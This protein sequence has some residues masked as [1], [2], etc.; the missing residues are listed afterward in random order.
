MEVNVKIHLPAPGM[1]DD[2]DPGF[3][4]KYMEG[5]DELWDQGLISPPDRELTTKAQWIG[6]KRELAQK[7][8]WV[9]HSEAPYGGP[10]QVIKYL[11]QY[12]NRVAISNNRIVFYRN[13]Q[14]CF[15]YKD[16]ADQGK[17]KKL[18]L[19]AERFARRFLLHVLPRGF[20]R[21]RYYGLF[22]SCKKKA[23]LAACKKLLGEV[24]AVDIQTGD[25]LSQNLGE[26]PIGIDPGRDQ[27]NQAETETQTRACPYCEGGKLTKV[28]KISRY[29]KWQAQLFIWRGKGFRS[30]IWDTS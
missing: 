11:A 8:K 13:N 23:C 14:V 15:H 7:K 1:Q 19:T 16:Y 27:A 10:Q 9:V 22:A 30:L 17:I 6:F 21:I 24:P 18:T 25:L 2:Q 29:L 28:S 26:Q 12:T 3:S 5:L 20:P 4:G